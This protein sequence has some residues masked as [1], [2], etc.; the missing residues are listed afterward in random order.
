MAKYTKELP[1]VLVLKRTFVQKFPNG[2]Q[3]ALYHSD[4][5]DQ[6]ITVPLIDSQFKTTKESVI[7][8]LNRISDE[9]IVENITFLDE[10]E[11]NINKEC[12]DIILN[13]GKINEMTFLEE[14]ISSEKSFLSLLE[15]TII[16]QEVIT[17]Q[18]SNQ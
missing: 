18:E 13:S 11:L 10:S 9:D 5:L 16:E 17:E 14:L 1:Q 7:E 12:A 4:L 3:V 15:Q 8:I 6:Y 2:Q